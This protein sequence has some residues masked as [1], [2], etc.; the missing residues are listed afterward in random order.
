MTAK[1]VKAGTRIHLPVT[2]IVIGEGSVFSVTAGEH[3]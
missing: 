1:R 3:V 2:G